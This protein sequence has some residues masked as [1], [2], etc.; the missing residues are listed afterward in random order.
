MEVKYMDK[1]VI[2]NAIER[3]ELNH[4]GL[5]HANGAY[6][7]SR[8]IKILKRTMLIIADVI[9]VRNQEEGVSERFNN[10]EYPFGIIG[11]K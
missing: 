7:K 6:I 1:K 9:I 2:K 3:Y 8:N 10:C 4:A 11:V 5:R